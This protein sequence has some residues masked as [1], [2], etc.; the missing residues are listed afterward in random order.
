MIERL[1]VLGLQHAFASHDPVAT[2]VE[3]GDGGAIYVEARLGAHAAIGAEAKYSAR[4]EETSTYGGRTGKLYLECA[5]LL[6]QAEAETVH[7]A[8]M[9]SRANQLA[10]YLLAS[11]PLAN[12]WLLDVG[13]GHFALDPAVAGLDRDCLDGNRHWFATPHAELLVT[14]RVERLELGP[15]RP[16]RTRSPSCTTGCN[17]VNNSPRLRVR[18]CATRGHVARHLLC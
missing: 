14:T 17:A 13:V 2:A 8:L 9:S 7:N 11:R 12:G 18:T 5:D 3:H 16:A 1:G 6:F 10:G 4:T 15:G